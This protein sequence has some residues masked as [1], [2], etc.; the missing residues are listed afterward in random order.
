[1]APY[2]DCNEIDYDGIQILINEISLEDEL[3]NART[4]A[5]L[6]IGKKWGK[7]LDLTISFRD[8][9]DENYVMRTRQSGAVKAGST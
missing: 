8:K 5:A 7:W 9:N 6:P 4:V 1:L 2:I 3:D